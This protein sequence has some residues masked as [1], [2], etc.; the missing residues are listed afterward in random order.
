MGRQ[1]QTREVLVTERIRQYRVPQYRLALVREATISTPWD[2]TVRQSADVAAFMTPLVTDLDRERFFVLMLDAK[3]RITGINIVATGSLNACLVHGREVFKP[4]ILANAASIL[5]AHNH[6]S[7][8]PTPSN[9][10]LL[11]SRRLHEA[12]LILGIAVLDSI[13]VTADEMRYC[14]L[15]DEGLLG[16]AR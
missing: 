16:G 10:D 11:L 14:S 13:V 12:G 2:K 15:A 8:D 4:A 9:D 5:L 7:S 6:P 1:R 3:H